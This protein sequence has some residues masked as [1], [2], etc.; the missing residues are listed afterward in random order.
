MACATAMPMGAYVANHLTVQLK[1]EPLP[2]PFRFSYLIQ[3]VSLGRHDGLV[4]FVEADDRPKRRVIT[5]WAAARIKE[6]ICRY[7]VWSLYQQR[8]WPGSYTWPQGRQILGGQADQSEQVRYGQP[9][10]NL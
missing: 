3:C 1:G 2:A 6:L 8:R 10:T 5:G 9:A 7:T 4:Q